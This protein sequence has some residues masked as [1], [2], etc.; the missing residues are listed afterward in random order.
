MKG[1]LPSVVFKKAVVFQGIR[2]HSV[3]PHDRHPHL[4]LGWIIEWYKA[5]HEN[6]WGLS[7]GSQGLS[8]WS[9]YAGLQRRCDI[10]GIMHF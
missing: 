4:T 10:D 1:G 6:K 8:D 7:P 5:K 2:K 9:Y 3:V